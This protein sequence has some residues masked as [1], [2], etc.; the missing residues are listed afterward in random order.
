M[1]RCKHQ[2]DGYCIR[3]ENDYCRPSQ[4]KGNYSITELCQHP[5]TAVVVL[6]TTVTCETTA[7]E[8]LDCGELL[9]KP[10]TDCR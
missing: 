7:L 5:N 9:T 4:C 2:T 10:E 6:N 8:C 3:P 1:I